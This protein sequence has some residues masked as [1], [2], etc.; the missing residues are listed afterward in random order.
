MTPLHSPVI[1]GRDVAGEVIATGSNV[2][3]FTPGQRVMGLVNRS[4][5]GLLTAASD[6]LTLIPDGLD[7]KQA[8]ALPLVTT[9]GAQLA[10]QIV[11][12][13]GD[14][15]LVTGAYGNVGRTELYRAKQRGASVIAAV[16]SAQKDAARS[17][18]ADRIVATDS[19]EEIASLPP[20][21]AI[22]DTVGGH[23]IEKLIPKLKPG[24]TLGSVLG[25]PKAAEGKNIRVKAV[26][27][28]SDAALLRELAEAVQSRALVIPIARQF[29]LSEPARRK[30][31]RNAAVSMGKSSWCRDAP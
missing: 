1:L 19:D 21:D 3:N 16:L 31:W 26:L 12:A 4:Y 28:Q 30:H 10:D 2:R 22:A 25:K 6:V 5:A 24:G 14:A 29:R 7:E 9:T 15:I 17:L 11:P 27:S 13:P 23:L 18:G 20:L 8:G